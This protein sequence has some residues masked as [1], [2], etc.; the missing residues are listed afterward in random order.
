MLLSH[1][2][3]SAHVKLLESREE[4]SQ[5]TMLLMVEGTARAKHQEPG[6]RCP[7]PPPLHGRGAFAQPTILE[8]TTSRPHGKRT[9]TQ[10]PVANPSPDLQN[11]PASLKR[12]MV[13]AQGFLQR[14]TT[15]DIW[16]GLPKVFK[17]FLAL[18]LKKWHFMRKQFTPTFKSLPGPFRFLQGGGKRVGGSSLRGRTSQWNRW[19][20]SFPKGLIGKECPTVTK[21]KIACKM[22]FSHRERFEGLCQI[23]N[24]SPL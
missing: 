3:V 14:S 4:T 22:D 18:E 1:D 13:A 11:L 9:E 8:A 20:E 5:S 10:Y 15:K 23:S 7:H 24:Q 16:K 6:S 12:G 19:K 2:W 21:N 17:S